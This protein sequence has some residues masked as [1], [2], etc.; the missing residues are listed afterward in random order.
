MSLMPENMSALSLLTLRLRARFDGPAPT[1][2]HAAELWR[3]AIKGAL[4]RHASDLLRELIR[5]E[6]HAAAEDKPR[7]FPTNQTTPGYVLRVE[8]G[9]AAPGL[10]PGEQ[11][12][13]MTFF[14]RAGRMALPLLYALQQEE[15]ESGI[16][17][18]RRHFAMQKLQAYRPRRGWYDI[19][20]PLVADAMLEHG[21]THEPGP[22]AP[23][24]TAER[25][26]LM[27]R[28]T[29]SL[30][31]EVK[32]TALT[33]VPAL[34]QL[35]GS[36]AER[37]NRLA[38][39]WNGGEAFDGAELLRLEAA[40]AAARLEPD[41]ALRHEHHRLPSGR[42]RHRPGRPAGLFLYSLPTAAAIELLPL[43]DLGQ[44]LHVGAHTTAGLGHYQLLVGAA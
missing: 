35:V 11:D 25:I 30:V 3:G 12:V 37:C 5:P 33:E 2:L 44:W 34:P 31:F 23:L 29:T 18:R 36:L 40:A 7:H 1:A 4:E 13:R 26:N 39:V 10:A 22:W 24:K 8:W 38:R 6:V 32:G 9:S 28:F 41:T 21:W 42:S 19:R 14:G 17:S 20:L 43:L 27:L 15:A 16:G